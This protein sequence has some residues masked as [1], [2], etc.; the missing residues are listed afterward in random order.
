MCVWIGPS[1]SDG[2]N[3]NIAVEAP[4]HWY[5]Y[6]RL[7]NQYIKIL[8]I[9]FSRKPKQSKTM[10]Q[11]RRINDDVLLKCFGL[12]SPPDLVT[13][14][15]V[16][17][18]WYLLTTQGSFF[19]EIYE[20]TILNCKW[21]DKYNARV[22][23][24][25]EID[26]LKL[27]ESKDN[28]DDEQAAKWRMKF[29]SHVSKFVNHQL[30]RR[31]KSKKYKEKCLS[32]ITCS[33]RF[34]NI[35][36]QNKLWDIHEFQNYNS[37]YKFSSFHYRSVVYTGDGDE[38]NHETYLTDAELTD[39]TSRDCVFSAL[40]W[41]GESKAIWKAVR[42]DLNAIIDKMKPPQTVHLLI[43]RGQQS[44]GETTTLGA[45]LNWLGGTR[46]SQSNEPSDRIQP[47]AKGNVNWCIRF[48]SEHDRLVDVLEKSINWHLE[49]NAKKNLW[50]QASRTQ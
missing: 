46:L 43:F 39:L 36:P 38:I 48:V 2:M 30:Q 41:D 42:K 25:C 17:L 32:R 21:I 6:Y 28:H 50:K 8:P 22:L 1:L 33:I 31:R 26:R 7:L 5:A 35:L 23:E 14:S 12:L 20:T 10:P 29:V 19:Q 4:S 15:R 40:A 44:P 34:I 18:R 45:L 13:C 37:L 24:D 27:K 9:H 16:S 3:E 11:C 49:K 47:L